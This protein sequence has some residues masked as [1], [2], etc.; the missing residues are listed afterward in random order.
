MIRMRTPG[1]HVEMRI[2]DVATSQHRPRIELSNEGGTANLDRTNRLW[3]FAPSAAVA[4]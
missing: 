2:G 4:Q 3:T 1:T